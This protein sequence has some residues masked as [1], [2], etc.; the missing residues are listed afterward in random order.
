MYRD[1]EK[2]FRS[3]S[4]E[5]GAPCGVEVA[6][7]LGKVYGRLDQPLSGMEAIRRALDAQPGDAR[8][9][10][11]MAR[12]HEGLGDLD[13]SVTA[14]KSLLAPIDIWTP[15]E[16][17]LKE[18]PR[19]GCDECGGHSVHC[20]P[21]L[22]RG[23]A[24]SRPAILS[25]PF[26]FLKTR[27][28]WMGEVDNGRR[29]LQM[30]VGKAAL[31]CNLGLCC[32][33]SQQ[34]DLAVGCVEKALALLDADTAADLWYNVGHIALVWHPGSGTGKRGGGVRWDAGWRGRGAGLPVLPTGTGH[35]RRARG[36]GDE[37]G[38][39]GDAAGA[40]EP[41]QVPL[42]VRHAHRRPHL[43]A[44]LQLRAAHLPGPH[45]SPLPSVA[46]FNVA[47]FPL[48]MGDFQ[49]SYGAVLQ[50]LAIFPEHADSAQLKRRLDK[51]F[52]DV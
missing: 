8:L 24:R 4:V 10:T 42:P 36:G 41:G 43:R 23:P 32:Y 22:L 13:V 3:A 19:G 26:S 15:G 18:R 52:T 1:A 48:Q 44:L 33:Y 20:H 50:S 47:L 27:R 7:Q 14:Y 45:P 16:G 12:L 2:Q 49:A 34:W 30:G 31:Y 37:P 29:L 21:L 40:A 11:A 51:L 5:E 38:R 9:L 35:G 17:E 28:V 6:L 25:V 46:L 39:G